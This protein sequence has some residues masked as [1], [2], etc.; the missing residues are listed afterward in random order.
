[1]LKMVI[2]QDA[3][4]NEGPTVDARTATRNYGGL[5]FFFLLWSRARVGAFSSMSAK[6]SCPGR[7]SR[8]PA[9]VWEDVEKLALVRRRATLRSLQDVELELR[10]VGVAWA[11]CVG[12]VYLHIFQSLESDQDSRRVLTFWFQPPCDSQL[13]QKFRTSLARSLLV[14]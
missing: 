1:M 9:P 10:H 3:S 12:L 2:R 5:A 8:G 6:Q 7:R 14:C 13:R 4:A 11:L